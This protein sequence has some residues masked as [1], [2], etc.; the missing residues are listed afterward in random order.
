[1][2]LCAIYTVHKETRIAGFLV[3]SQNQGSWVSRFEPQN[4]QLRFG[5]LAHKINATVSWFGPQNQVGYGLSVVPQ[6]HMRQDLASCF[7]WKQ[8]RLGFFSFASKLAKERRR[9]VHVAS[10]QR[11]RGSEVED[12]W[13]DG[14]GCGAVEV[15]Q[16]YPS[17]D[18]I[19]A[20]RSEFSFQFQF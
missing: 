11:S 12:G 6:N 9:V 19:A 3:K 14:V 1:M 4:R 16:K 15:R 17:L 2:T 20:R 7:A 10:S 13:S 5:D 8:V 18:I